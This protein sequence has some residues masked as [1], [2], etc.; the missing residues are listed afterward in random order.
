MYYDDDKIYVQ[1]VCIRNNNNKIY[2]EKCSRANRWV[3]VLN[4]R[5]I[6]IIIII[7]VQ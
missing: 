6:I 5:I 4:V 2:L 7:N 1:Y 3:V